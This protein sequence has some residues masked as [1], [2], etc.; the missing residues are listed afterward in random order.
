MHHV[1]RK[2]SV[3]ALSTHISTYTTALAH[4]VLQLLFSHGS[5]NF[6]HVTLHYNNYKHLVGGMM[7]LD[8]FAYP[9]LRSH[10]TIADLMLSYDRASIYDWWLPR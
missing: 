3:Y 10:S 2:H 1:Q 4:Y 6:K 7:Y 9:D 5:E 8:N